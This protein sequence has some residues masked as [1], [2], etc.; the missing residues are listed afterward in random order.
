MSTWRTTMS[1]VRHGQ[2]EPNLVPGDAAEE[3]TH[4]TLVKGSTPSPTSTGEDSI[5]IIIIIQSRRT[6]IARSAT[7]VGTNTSSSYLIRPNS[8][9]FRGAEIYKQI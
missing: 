7:K 1:T 8:R 5:I 4:R 9:G 6:I 2:I 3:I